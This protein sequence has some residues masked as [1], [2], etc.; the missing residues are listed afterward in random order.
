[1]IMKI[2]NSLLDNPG[3]FA[4]VVFILGTI[5]GSFLNVCI[6]RLP[7][8]KSV[9]WPGSHC[10][11]CL[12]RIRWY[13]NVPLLSYLWLQ[14]KCRQCGAK[15]SSRYFW[16]ELLTGLAFAG[17]FW[18]EVRWNILGIG[19]LQLSRLVIWAYHCVLICF[20]M[21]AFFTDVDHQEIPLSITIPG[22]VLGVLGGT[23]F[24]WPWPMEPV[25]VVPSP[26]AEVVNFGGLWV[27]EDTFFPLQ[28]GLQRWPAWMPTAWPVEPGTWVMGL[29]TSLAGILVGWI[30]FWL[31]RVVF[32]WALG[33]EAMGLGDADLM[34]M[35]GAFL[36]W[37]L[38]FWVF[39][40]ALPIALIY[41]LLQ[42]LRD[43]GNE[44]P[45]GPFLALGAIVA[46]VFS[47]SLGAFSQAAFFDAVLIIRLLM[48]T[49][50]LGL[51]VILTLRMFRLV[52]QA[53]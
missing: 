34:M 53:A 7:L 23:L 10:G 11:S 18:L 14:G 47:F 37:Q 38:L 19:G 25:Q 44:L 39:L 15:Y 41:A 43:K 13:D 30:S 51:F 16:I 32:T 27:R 5:V 31:I 45:F 36:G 49:V 20:L 24:P 21:V 29:V 8:Q 17:L 50:V 1:M 4:L 9:L 26:L 33:K 6:A 3:W 2:I 22:T 42:F 40:A 12:K 48:V 46:T 28:P 35:I 52:G